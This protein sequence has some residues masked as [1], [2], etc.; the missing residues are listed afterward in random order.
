MA[1]PEVIQVCLF[2]F[3]LWQSHL[4]IWCNH[5]MNSMPVVPPVTQTLWTA[6]CRIPALPMCLDVYPAG[7]PVLFLQLSY[8]QAYLSMPL[9]H[10]CLCVCLFISLSFYLV[11]GCAWIS[12]QL[13]KI[14]VLVYIIFWH[15]TDV[16]IAVFSE[17]SMTGLLHLFWRWL[18]TVYGM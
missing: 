18:P 2:F 15:F 17:A 4:W 3:L 14:L 7:S 6:N 9:L 16:S 1:F 8:I 11:H 5:W 13:W 10:W 12:N